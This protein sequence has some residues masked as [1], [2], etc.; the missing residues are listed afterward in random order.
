MDVNHKEEIIVSENVNGITCE[1]PVVDEGETPTQNHSAV[2]QII[3]ENGIDKK[4]LQSQIQ[5]T[6]TDLGDSFCKSEKTPTND[7]N[8]L[9]RIT[10]ESKLRI[11]TENC[12]LN[13]VDKDAYDT[14]S[15][16][17][18]TLEEVSSSEDLREAELSDSLIQQIQLTNE[19]KQCDKLKEP[20]VGSDSTT[21]KYD[22]L[23][24]DTTSDIIPS[25]DDAFKDD[26]NNSTIGAMRPYSLSLANSVQSHSRNRSKSDD[27]VKVKDRKQTVRKERTQSDTIEIKASKYQGDPYTSDDFLSKSLP[28]G[29]IM[30]KGDLIEFVAKDLEE[31]IRHSSPMSLTGA[32]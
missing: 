27:H 20:L 30:R 28:K 13:S 21:K 17:I 11:H 15:D 3:L 24:G 5:C 18:E 9:S 1:I 10:E 26:D 29:T 19:Q 25:T 7:I 6:V 22:S 32:I 16:S 12:L 4:Q 2:E 14:H 31:K 8:V 23:P